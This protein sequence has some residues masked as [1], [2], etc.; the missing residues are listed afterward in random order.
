MLVGR[1]VGYHYDRNAMLHR[2]V[3]F[4]REGILFRDGS[5]GNYRYIQKRPPRAQG[6]PSPPAAAA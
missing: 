2:L 1:E 6:E 4:V 5:S 3:D